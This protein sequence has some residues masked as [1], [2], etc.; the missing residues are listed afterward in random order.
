ME[1]PKKR[2]LKNDVQAKAF[3]ALAHS[4]LFEEACDVAMLE[5]VEMQSINTT[6]ALAQAVRLQG[7]KQFRAILENLGDETVAQKQPVQGLDYTQ[8]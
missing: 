5:L 6:D 4:K 3:A 8:Q 2:F 1:S 7:A